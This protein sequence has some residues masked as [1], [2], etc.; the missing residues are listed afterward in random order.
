MHGELSLL[1]NIT[2]GLVV[3]FIGGLVARRIGLPT[4]VGYLVA[5]V[6]IGPFTPGFVGD[7][8]TISQ[9]A[10][11][12]VIFLMFGVG[13]HFSLK[14]LWSV[15]SIAIPGAILQMIFVTLLGF[16]LGQLWGWS[17]PASLTLGLA[18]SIASTVVL[19][20][21]LMEHH[22][23]NTIHG[24]VAVGWL[25]LEDMATVL[26][27]VLLPTLFGKEAGNGLSGIAIALFKA[28]IFVMIMLLAGS[29]LLPW[30]FK[31]IDLTESRELFILA[32]VAVAL[33]T[34]V[35]AA[36]LFGVSLALGAFLAGVVLGES[37]QSH[38]INEEIVPFRDIFAVLFFV[39]VG[40][41]VNPAELVSNIGHVVALAAL[42]LIGKPLLTLLFGFILPG[43]GRTFLVAAAGLSQ[44]GEFSFIVGQTALALGLITQQQYGLIL[45]GAL[46]S[47]TL[48]P[49]IFK[50]IPAAERILQRLPGVWRRLDRPQ[51]EG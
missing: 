19:L 51:V 49:F 35:G 24:K 12:G 14:D 20:R 33:G 38:Q 46:I 21:S 26:I 23:L 9:L 29:R 31:R 25:V 41:L 13:L 32:V 28:F 30:L 2:V 4:I 37:S 27:L 36:Q 1:L 44:I 8:H 45:A 6:V 48:N 43:Q 34:A 16:V 3:A 22:L 39:S 15:R 42:I 18:L 10:E 40:M 7:T 47:I 17:V 11:I 5:G 50:T